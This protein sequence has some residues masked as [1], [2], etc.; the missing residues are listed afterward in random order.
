MKDRRQIGARHIARMRGAFRGGWARPRRR[1]GHGVDPEADG[2]TWAP[3]RERGANVAPDAA[4]RQILG[5]DFPLSAA[6][7]QAAQSL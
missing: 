4:R 2:A 1:V 6:G 7:G 3:V 5:P